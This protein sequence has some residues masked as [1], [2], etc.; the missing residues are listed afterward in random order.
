MTAGS[1]MNDNDQLKKQYIFK[2]VNLRQVVQLAEGCRA[3]P[4]KQN[5]EIE[6]K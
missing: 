3:F 4:G 1:E 2:T 5:P 6:K